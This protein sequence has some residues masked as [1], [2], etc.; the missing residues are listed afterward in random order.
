MRRR[1]AVDLVGQH[2]LRE[3]R[4]RLEHELARR[5]V[6]HTGADQVAG[7]KI[8]REL[9]AMEGAVDAA[10]QRLGEQ[11]LADAGHVLD[12]EV[13][14]GEECDEGVANAIGVAE[15]DGGDVLLQPFEHGRVGVIVRRGGDCA[16][17][18]HEMPRSSAPWRFRHDYRALPAL[19]P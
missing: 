9:N 4:A 5:L 13:P 18:R 17:R 19:T 8:G 3:Q 7:E 2:H 15:K 11:G 12:E 10:G 1:G 16:V 14:F 6:I